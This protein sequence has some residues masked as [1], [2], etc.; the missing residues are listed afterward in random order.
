VQNPRPAKVPDDCPRPHSLPAERSTLGS[1]LRYS[2]AIPDVALFLIA[3]DFYADANQHVYRAVLERW[4][5]GGPVDLVTVAETLKTRGVTQD[6][7][8]AYLSELWDNEP[9]GCNAAYYARIVKDKALVR[10]CLLAACEI[11]GAGREGAIA[12]DEL[13]QLAERA[14]FS[15]GELGVEADSHGLP[16]TV[17]MA[18]DAIDRRATKGED[19]GLST[20]LLD[21][22][23]ITG[24][25]HPGELVIIGARPSVGKT[26]LAARIALHAARSGVAPFFVSLEQRRSE[27][28]ERFLCMES[29]IDSHLTHTGRLADE[30]WKLLFRAKDSLWPLR[31]EISDTPVQS[32]TRIAANARRLRRK[33]KIGLVLI[34]YLQLIEPE[35]RKVN[36]EQQVAAITLK[37]KHLAREMAVPVVLLAQLNRGPEEGHGR[38]PRLSD[39]RESGAQEQDAD[40]VILLWRP[41]ERDPTE[42]VERV[43]ALV[44]KNRNRRTGECYLAFRKRCMRFENYTVEVREWPQPA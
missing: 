13:L 19:R 37:A 15:V 21:L 12:G 29:A 11:Y 38:K 31:M 44:E 23:E 8:Y 42:P 25:L 35:D 7:G 34:D 36:R 5:Q 4:A 26:S 6:V 14:V 22:D 1:L 28:G 43:Q 18:C 16:S 41:E 3:E 32:M 24:G 39:L 9:T 10:R 27:L 30:D 2:D 20:G 40:V 33:H 17:D